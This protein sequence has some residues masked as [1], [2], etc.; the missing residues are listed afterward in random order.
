ML[1]LFDGCVSDILDRL[2]RHRA[3][4]CWRGSNWLANFVNLIIDRLHWL[5][6][7]VLLMLSFRQFF[8]LF[9]VVTNIENSY[10][11]VSVWLIKL[12][13]E[14]LD[15]TFSIFVAVV[16][17]VDAYCRNVE[18]CLFEIWRLVEHCFI[19][20]DTINHIELLLRLNCHNQEWWPFHIL[21]WLDNLT[22]LLL[23]LYLNVNWRYHFDVLW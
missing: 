10:V 21:F 5:D 18:S 17:A 6:V 23:W 2:G 16:T 13:R 20:S 12:R 8:K 4:L 3:L 7:L 9:I 14:N 15:G 11:E 22:T 19:I 1:N